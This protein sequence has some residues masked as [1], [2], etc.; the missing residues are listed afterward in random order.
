MQKE[1]FSAV[2]RIKD[3][4]EGLGASGDL[5]VVFN[6]TK[7]VGNSMVSTAVIPKELFGEL[8]RD[9]RVRVQFIRPEDGTK[10]MVT[11]LKFI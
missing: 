8:A 4:N 9:K 6:K 11:S 5:L 2:G 3:D 7:K 1:V 10:P